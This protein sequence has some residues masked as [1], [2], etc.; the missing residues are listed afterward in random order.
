MLCSPRPFG[1][2]RLVFD[3]AP[4]YSRADCISEALIR[5]AKRFCIQAANRLKFPARRAT[6]RG[7]NSR[8]LPAESYRRILPPM[9][10][11]IHASATS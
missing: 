7:M 8:I 2:R 1:L 11:P 5:E 3:S 4:E 10:R 6:R 9:E